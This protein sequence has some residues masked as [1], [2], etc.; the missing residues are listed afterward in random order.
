MPITTTFAVYNIHTQVND[1]CLVT[2]SLKADGIATNSRVRILK[3]TE[4]LI[5]AQTIDAFPRIIYLPRIRFKF[6]LRYGTSFK[7]LRTQFPLRLA[8]AMTYNK[9]QGQ[10]MHKTL[11]DITT[12]PFAHGHLYVG[13]SRVRCSTNMRFYL[14]ED[15]QTVLYPPPDGGDPSNVPVVTNVVHKCVLRKLL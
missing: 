9:S 4:R 8:Y 15:T 14:H 6:S 7:M 3:I 12:P 11:L 13:D 1:I 2:R 5:T 10:T